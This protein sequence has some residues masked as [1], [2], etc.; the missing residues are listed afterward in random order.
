AGT[1]DAHMQTDDWPGFPSAQEQPLLKIAVTHA[2]YRRVLDA[3]VADGADLVFAG[4]TH[5]GQV[6]LPA[7]GAIVSNCELPTGVASGSSPWRTAGR[8][9]LVNV[10]AGIGASPAVP[11]RTF[12]PPEAVV[13]D[14]VPADQTTA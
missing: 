11:L 4:H 14:L 1:H 2:P 12:C 7:Y 13:I 5:G 3:A 9:A 8:T 10:T 6:A